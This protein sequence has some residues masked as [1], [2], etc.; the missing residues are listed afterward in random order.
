MRIIKEEPLEYHTF[1]SGAADNAAELTFEELQRLD[2]LL[3]LEYPE[4]I[5]ETE[6]NDKMWFEF[7]YICALLGKK[8]EE[9]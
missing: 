8:C 9:D 4:G 1:W 7:D 3:T 2:Q 5:N 6:L